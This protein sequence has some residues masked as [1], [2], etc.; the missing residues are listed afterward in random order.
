[1]NQVI[2]SLASEVVNHSIAHQ[3]ITHFIHARIQSLTNSDQWGMSTQT[4]AAV[5]WVGVVLD[6]RGKP[7]AVGLAAAMLLW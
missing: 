3:L 6:N 1:M 2:Y 4:K 7:H 5:M